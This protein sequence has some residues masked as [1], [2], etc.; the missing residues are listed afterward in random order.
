MDDA[1]DDFVLEADLAVR[2]QHD[3]VL[4]VGA[5]RPQSLDHRIGHLRPAVLAASKGHD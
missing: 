2:D 1:R 5:Q 4:R 3:L